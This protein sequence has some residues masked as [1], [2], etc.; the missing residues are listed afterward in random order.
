MSEN[1]TASKAILSKTASVAAESMHHGVHVGV[2]TEAARLCV[3]AVKRA[4][5]DRY[6]KAFQRE[7]FQS[8]EPFVAA[9]LVH[10]LAE[11]FAERFPYA[12][13]AAATAAAAMEGS[14][15]DAFTPFLAVVEDAFKQFASAAIQPPVY[16]PGTRGL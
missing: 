5:G 8:L 15:R 6:P 1:T 13:A 11:A 12:R 9:F 7:P 14:A 4:L 16:Y 2:S 10:L 3:D